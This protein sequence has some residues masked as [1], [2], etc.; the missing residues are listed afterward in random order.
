M[1]SE[2]Y[3]FRLYRLPR[4]RNDAQPAVLN[5][6]RIYLQ[7]SSMGFLAALNLTDPTTG[8]GKMDAV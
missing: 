1:R 3:P 2:E 4:C 5:L 8:H 7:S 6:L